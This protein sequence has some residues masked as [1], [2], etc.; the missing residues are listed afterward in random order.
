MPIKTYTGR[1]EYIHRSVRPS[2]LKDEKIYDAVLLTI[3]EKKGKNVAIV[4][5]Q[6]KVPDGTEYLNL[7]F[8]TFFGIDTIQHAEHVEQPPGE[9]GGQRI[10]VHDFYPA[11]S[12]DLIADIENKNRKV[13]VVDFNNK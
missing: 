9:D 1:V 12:S 3:L 8:K 5:D 2:E 13:K 7:V 4:T 6:N 11:C 10:H